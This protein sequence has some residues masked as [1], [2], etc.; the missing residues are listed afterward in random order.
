MELTAPKENHYR[1]LVAEDDPAQAKFATSILEKGGMKT[2]S[3]TDPLKVL[4]A[5]DEFRPDLILMDL[6]MPNASG[7]ELTAIIREH[8]DFVATPI[9][10]LSGEQDA[11]KKLEA[12]STGADDFL[13]KPIRPRHLIN[14]ITNRVQRAKS[15]STRGQ[16]QGLR[17]PSSGLFHRR[18]FFQQLENAVARNENQGI[19]GAVLCL[20]LPT[21]NGL[22]SITGESEKTELIAA[23][24]GVIS[25]QLEEQDIAARVDDDNFAIL[26]IRPHEK[27]ILTLAERVAQAVNNHPIRG[28]LGGHPISHIGI[29]PFNSAAGDAAG[30]LSKATKAADSIDKQCNGI[31]FHRTDQGADQRSDQLQSLIRESWEKQ[32]IQLLYQP[33][34]SKNTPLTEQYHVSLRLLTA[35]GET[36]PESEFYS[37][38]AEADLTET[39]NQWLL[40]HV[41]SSL[42]EK[43]LE[44]KQAYFFI[45][46]ALSTV[47]QHNNFLGWLINQL[48]SRQMVGSGLVFEFR[49]AELGS[50][51]K[52]AKRFL[53]KLQELGIQISL[54]RFGANRAALTVLQYLKA[55][56]ACLA[57]QL[58]K[59]NQEKAERLV[60]QIHEAGAKVAIPIPENR[61]VLAT[62]W[63]EHADLTP[64]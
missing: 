36:I 62:H 22:D 37:G 31:E 27:N 45:G 39:I 19:N 10:F 3:I 18:H 54:S 56:Y 58:L 21:I 53:T 61:A 60:A 33:L 44:G 26:A 12:L 2:L 52:S 49:I 51:I 9:V 55:D 28:A 48:R 35:G 30:M 24:G 11:D 59:A 41:L 14:T 1:I 5:L 50:D 34:T 25:A 47:E 20:S 46:Q 43:R 17:D 64:G 16:K 6:Y 23:L 7:T 57:E 40:E 15:L 29:T 63:L 8:P 4:D 32:S 38:I 13:T 42:A